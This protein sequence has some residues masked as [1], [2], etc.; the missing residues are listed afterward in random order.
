MGREVYHGQGHERGTGRKL[1]NS[2]LE[3]VMPC[4][5][6]CFVFLAGV[7][8]APSVLD[9][10]LIIKIHRS[11]T[12]RNKVKSFWKPGRSGLCVTAELGLFFNSKCL[13]FICIYV[14]AYVRD[15]HTHRHTYIYLYTYIHISER[16]GK[17]GSVQRGRRSVQ[18]Q[19]AT[20]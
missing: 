15:A 5:I 4:F 19:L 9:C 1:Y 11:H 7:V 16:Q 14:S 3:D 17:K 18:Q 20:C 10:F 13:D 2:Y 6:W 12:V 8:R